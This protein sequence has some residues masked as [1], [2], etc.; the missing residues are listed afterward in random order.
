MA[1]QTVARAPWYKPSRIVWRLPWLGLVFALATV[2]GFLII[3]FVGL[4]IAAF[5][6][7]DFGMAVAGAGLVF[8]VLYGLVFAW[9]ILPNIVYFAAFAMVIV[10]AVL[11]FG[12]LTRKAPAFV[13]RASERVTLFYKSLPPSQLYLNIALWF[14]IVAVMVFQFAPFPRVNHSDDFIAVLSINSRYTLPVLDFAGGFAIWRFDSVSAI[15]GAL[16]FIIPMVISLGA[17]LALSYALFMFLFMATLRP[18]SAL[19][20]KRIFYIVALAL[21]TV[22]PFGIVPSLIWSDTPAEFSFALSH[23]VLFNLLAPT[24]LLLVISLAW[25]YFQRA[26]LAALGASVKARARWIALGSAALQA[27]YLVSWSV[28]A[29]PNINAEAEFFYIGSVLLAAFV[30]V[31]WFGLLLMVGA[32]RKWDWALFGMV[33]ATQIAS[34]IVV[35][36]GF[37]TA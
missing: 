20:L 1:E 9:G 31:A 30:A 6:P 23:L 29:A 22:A 36:P 13:K 5:P 17:A 4:T 16:H 28:F 27:S 8:A 26:R 14:A 3:I 11:L 12:G 32:R 2:I 21:A 25:F 7:S 33:V 37:L 18:S 19:L 15:A 34:L 10:S 35:Y 24:F